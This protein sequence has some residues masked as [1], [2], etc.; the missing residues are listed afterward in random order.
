MFPP[1]ARVVFPRTGVRRQRESRFLAAF[2]GALNGWERPLAY[3]GLQRAPARLP[4]VEQRHV[5]RARRTTSSDQS[6]SAREMSKSAAAR[7]TTVDPGVPLEPELARIRPD[8]N[9]ACSTSGLRM[10]KEM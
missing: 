8:E 3:Q 5:G 4:D 7:A 2:P 1:A 9:G 10:L 6:C